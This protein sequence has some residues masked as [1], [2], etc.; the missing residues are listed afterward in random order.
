MSNVVE[1]FKG[2]EKYA[3]KKETEYVEKFTSSEKSNIN[4]MIGVLS[5]VKRDLQNGVVFS[6]SFYDITS[7]ISEYLIKKINIIAEE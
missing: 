4:Y 1:L 6:K 7:K 5:C 2:N 3:R